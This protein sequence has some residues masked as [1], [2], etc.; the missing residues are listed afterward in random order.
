MKPFKFHL[1]P[2]LEQRAR[3]EDAVKEIYAKAVQTHARAEEDLRQGRMELE[4]YHHALSAKREGTSFRHDQLLFLTALQQQQAAC[5]RLAGA[6]FLANREL[7]KR[8]VELLTAHRKHEALLHLKASRRAEHQTA[9]QR[10]EELMVAD[11]ITARYA[12]SLSE[13]QS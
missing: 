1:D 3:E 13:D 11:I 8:R 7:E 4:A 10:E 2:V 5:Q 12:M 6:L 9:L